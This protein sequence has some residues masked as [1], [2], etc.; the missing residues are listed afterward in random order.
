MT[1]G[2][3]RD[4]ERDVFF[5]DTLEVVVFVGVLEGVFGLLRGVALRGD[6]PA[7]TS[8]SAASSAARSDSK[9]WNA[10][11]RSSCAASDSPQ[12]SFG[13]SA[14]RKAPNAGASTVR[15]RSGP[16]DSLAASE[17]EYA[18]HRAS[19]RRYHDFK[20]FFNVS[21]ED[22]ACAET[23]SERAFAASPGTASGTTSSSP[24]NRSLSLSKIVVASR[25]ASLETSE[26]TKSGSSCAE[27]GSAA[28]NLSTSCAVSSHIASSISS[29][30]APTKAAGDAAEM[31]CFSFGRLWHTS[32]KARS[33]AWRAALCGRTAAA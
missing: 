17:G 30:L 13:G 21:A 19:V 16:L 33:A 8:K 14:R 11:K 4:V 6:L 18:L 9:C 31:T 22:S 5:A 28:T 25:L 23:T 10:A 32:T 2:L 29:S 27:K 24:S 1:R 3:T 20:C 15:A 26:T 7:V 12:R